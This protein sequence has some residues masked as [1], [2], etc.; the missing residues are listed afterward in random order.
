MSITLWLEPGVAQ[1]G[2]FA[3]LLLA[4]LGVCVWLRRELFPRRTQSE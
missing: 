4:G 2:I 1:A 3:T